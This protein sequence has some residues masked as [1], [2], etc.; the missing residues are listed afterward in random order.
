V[1]ELIAQG[2][3]HQEVGE[4]L[5]ITTGTV[6]RHLSNACLRLDARNTIVLVLRV[7]SINAQKLLT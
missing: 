7:Y 6:G 2:L 4:R 1:I 5:C 3:S